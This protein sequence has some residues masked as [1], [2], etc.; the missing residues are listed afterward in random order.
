MQGIQYSWRSLHIINV[1]LLLSDMEIVVLTEREYVYGASLTHS[2]N[3]W[4]HIWTFAGALNYIIFK[5]C[6]CINTALTSSLVPRFVVNDYFCD[7]AYSRLFTNYNSYSLQSSDP[8]WDGTGYGPTNT[9]CSC[10]NP[11][12]FVKQL[13]SPTKENVEM[14][15]CKQGVGT[16]LLEIIELYVQ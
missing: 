4:K 9:C 7:A 16:T 2:Q 15:V 3:P 10:N 1:F 13:P 11:P 8:L 14:R 5:C 12:W 6:P